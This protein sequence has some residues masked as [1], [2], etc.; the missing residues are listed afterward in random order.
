MELE[1][2][3]TTIEQMELTSKERIVLRDYL[4]QF[5]DRWSEAYRNLYHEIKDV[6]K[7]ESKILWTLLKWAKLSNEEKWEILRLIYKLENRELVCSNP[8]TQHRYKIKIEEIS[9]GEL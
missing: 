2:K 6:H 1:N 7:F 5:S 3:N 8:P 9:S 4:N